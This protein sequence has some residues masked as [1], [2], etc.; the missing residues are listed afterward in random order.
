MNRLILTLG[1]AWLL[2]TLVWACGQAEGP[3]T[4]LKPGTASEPLVFQCAGG[5][6][7]IVEFDRKGENILFKMD[8]LSIKLPQVPSGSG[9]K[10]SDGRTTVWMKGEEAFVVVDGNIILRDCQIRK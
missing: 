1:I 7:F 10:Y 4:A 3:A 9:A 6:S 2:L 8:N 5:Q